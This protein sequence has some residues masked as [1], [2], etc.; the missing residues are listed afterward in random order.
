MSHY[1]KFIITNMN[2]K[3]RNI[4]AKTEI[5]FKRISLI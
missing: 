2:S 1:L 4:F 3:E 5:V